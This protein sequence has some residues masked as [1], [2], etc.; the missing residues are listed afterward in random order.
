MKT[1]NFKGIDYLFRPNS[2]CHVA[3][4]LS[5]IL[6]NVK[7]TN[8]RQMIIDYWNANNIEEL[9]EVLLLD[10]LSDQQRQNLGRIH[11]SFMGGEY[12][13]ALKANEVEIARLELQS[14]TSDVI[15]I[16]AT[17]TPACIRYRIVDEYDTEFC[18]VRKTS[19]HPLTLKQ[20]IAFITRSGDP[21]VDGGL[22]L[23]YNNLNT[24]GYIRGDRARL[25][26]FTTI[27]SVFYPQLHEHFEQVFEEWTREPKEVES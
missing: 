20:L 12:L 13:P 2:Y 23:A 17:H 7:G 5:A 4:P 16:R 24:E 19:R 26:H 6:L 15:S 3:D 21:R 11:P 1:K 8:R 22:A 14:V 27:T 9:D 18:Q 10:S 25:R